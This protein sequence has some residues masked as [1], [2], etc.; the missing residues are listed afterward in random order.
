MPPRRQVDIRRLPHGL[1]Y[2][3]A[4]AV[5]A[6]VIGLAWLASRDEPSPDWWGRYA[7]PAILWISPVAFVLL[8]WRYVRR[9][10]RKSKD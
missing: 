6:F 8:V 1:G 10:R 3:L 5:V 4:L 2:I 9:L 7:A